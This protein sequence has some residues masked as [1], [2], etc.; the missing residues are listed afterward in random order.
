MARVLIVED[1]ADVSQLLA[2][3]LRSYGHVVSTAPSARM[4][5]N[6]VGFDFP[7]DVA[8]LDIELPA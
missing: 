4:A 8:V 2:R 5:M 7:A 6:V 3:R 1:D